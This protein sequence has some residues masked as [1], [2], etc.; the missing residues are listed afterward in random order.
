[1][2][3]SIEKK[4]FKGVSWLAAFKLFSQISSWIATIIVANL[5]LPGDYG[6]MAMATIITGYAEI[7]SELG[8]GAAIIQKDNSTK[9]ELSSVFWFAFLFACF[10]SAACFPI[11][12]ITA[13]LLNEPRVI[14]ITQTVSLLFFLSGFQVVPINLLKKELDFK[15][16][17]MI[18]MTSTILSCFGMIIIAYY[19]GGVWTLIGGRIIRNFVRLILLY[20]K[21]KWIPIW[22]FNWSEAKSYV[23][24]GVTMAF[25]TSLFYIWEQSDKFF[26]GRAWQPAAVGFYTFALQLSQIPTEKIVVLINQVS[27][28]AFSKLQNDKEKF[29]RF[30]LNITKITATIVFPLFIGGFLVGP[31]LIKILFNEKWYPIIFLFKYLC[32]S[33]ILTAVNAVNNFVH[34]SQGRPQWGLTY[35]AICVIFMPVSF[36]FAVR[37]GLEAIILPWLTTYFILCSSWIVVTLCKIGIAISEYIKNIQNAICASLVMVV[38]VVLF[39]HASRNVPVVPDILVLKLAISVTIG[40]CVYLGYL[41][42]FDREIFESFKKM[43][44]R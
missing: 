4:T 21:V 7:F 44:K 8:L 40:G 31:D 27:F 3:E 34:A 26:A 37:Y 2:S 9:E 41:W 35:H 20:Y 42:K 32:L 6:L 25:G 29:N 22:Y 36:Y 10:L 43:L 5:L 12:K 15:M 19:G 1:M 14:P 38:A 13:I 28:S 17:G 24:F 39:Q 23:K 18:E 16:V 11:A 33:Q 30:Y